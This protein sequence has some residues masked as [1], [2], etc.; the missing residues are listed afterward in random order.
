MLSTTYPVVSCPRIPQA[1]TLRGAMRAI[2]SVKEI[3]AFITA[4]TKFAK[5]VEM[6]LV[7]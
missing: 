4:R 7:D 1:E 2:A 6:W 3:V 5:V